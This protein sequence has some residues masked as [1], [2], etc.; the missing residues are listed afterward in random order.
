[1][2][3]RPDPI[4]IAIIDDHPFVRDGVRLC[5]ESLPHLCVIGEAGDAQAGEQLI[6]G[7]RPDLALID[8]GL[9]GESGLDLI[10]RLARSELPTRL[11]VLTMYDSPEYVAKAMAAGARAYVLKDA[12]AEELFAAIDAVLAGGCYYSSGVLP[13]AAPAAAPAL[14]TQREK[15]VLAMLA[16]GANNKQIS[17]KLGMSVRT[18]ETHRL[19]IKRKVGIEGT[20]ALLKYAFGRA[21]ERA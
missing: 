15:E 18:V 6:R 3:T 4:R 1:M 8:I 19:N 21:W 12:P 10:G 16:D 11:V 20:S 9:R 2:T 13:L 14:L 7:Q 5:I 17:A